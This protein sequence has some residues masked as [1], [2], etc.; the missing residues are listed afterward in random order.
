MSAVSAP[1]NTAAKVVAD[2]VKKNDWKTIASMARQNTFIDLAFVVTLIGLIVTFIFFCFYRMTEIIY[3]WYKRINML[4]V[5]KNKTSPTSPSN[6]LNDPTNDN[7]TYTS[8]VNSDPLPDAYAQMTQA[9]Q[10]SFKGYADYNQ[11]LTA[12]YNNVKDSAPPDLMDPSV[13]IPSNDNW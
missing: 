12:Y 5:T 2:L 3:R 13:L 7:E 10:N 9:I 1:I 11:K 4:S 6:P 8:G